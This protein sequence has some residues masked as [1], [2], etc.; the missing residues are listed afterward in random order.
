L[1]LNSSYHQMQN[2]EIADRLIYNAL[3]NYE[4]EASQS[5]DMT[6]LYLL[7]Q[8]QSKMGAAYLHC[9]DYYKSYHSLKKAIDN[10]K[11]IETCLF[12]YQPPLC[13]ELYVDFAECWYQ[14]YHLLK[15]LKLK[16]LRIPTSEGAYYPKTCLTEAMNN[17]NKALTIN[18]V[19]GIRASDLRENIF[20]ENAEMRK[21]YE[22]SFMTD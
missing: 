3:V 14:Y 16:Q 19:Y 15:Q 10:Y 22:A 17:I 8:L 9:S 12:N 20:N 5:E 6:V 4:P 21:D 7:A 2:S 1:I 11:K 18:S 13:Y